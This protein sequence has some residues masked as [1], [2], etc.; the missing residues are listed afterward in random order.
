MLS[1]NQAKQKLMAAM[2]ELTKA[3]E[4]SYEAMF[5]DENDMEV[6]AFLYEA[7]QSAEAALSMI[8]EIRERIVR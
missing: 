7:E 6:A 8:K 1:S 3:Q 2:R 4:R 5:T